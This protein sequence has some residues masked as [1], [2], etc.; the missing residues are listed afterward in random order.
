[1]G[2]SKINTSLK[3]YIK[4]LFHSESNG[5]LQIEYWFKSLSGVEH[6]NIALQKP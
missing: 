1:M 5:S 6:G 3:P 2:K 4:I